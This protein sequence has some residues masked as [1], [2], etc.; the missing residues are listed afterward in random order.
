MSQRD[1]SE[2]GVYAYRIGE[3][4]KTSSRSVFKDKS[5]L[6]MS[7]DGTLKRIANRDQVSFFKNPVEIDE[8]M[9]VRVGDS[10]FQDSKEISSVV[11]QEGIR[12]IESHAFKNASLLK[13]IELPEGLERIG[14]EAFSLCTSLE[15]VVFPKSLKFLGPRAF[16]GCKNLKRI[17]F[18]ESKSFLNGDVVLEMGSMAFSECL[19]IEEIVFPLIKEIP[20]GAF[21]ECGFKEVH[22]PDSLERI[23]SYA[24]SRCWALS[25]IYFDGPLKDLRRVELG[26]NWNRDLSDELV[27]YALDD[28]GSYFDVMS[29][30]KEKSDRDDNQFEGRGSVP[31]YIERAMTDLGIISVDFT[32][33]ELHRKYLEK[34]KSFH[35]DRILALNLDSSYIEFASLKFKELTEE[36]ELLK[37]YLSRKGQ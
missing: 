4:K 1:I 29:T 8:K 12:E 35:P 5:E 11:L 6:I 24:F 30:Q 15:E 19:S 32:F 20:D 28:N 16:L 25:K 37:S 26:L 10:L 34:A 7:E 9:A 3:R 21:M 31:I 23:G 13:S 22:L 27:L 36:Y 2:F 33:D 14:E 17:I 18:Q